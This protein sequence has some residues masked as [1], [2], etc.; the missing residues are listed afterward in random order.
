MPKSVKPWDCKE[1]EALKK[2]E[3]LLRYAGGKRK[4]ADEIMASFPQDFKYYGEP[5]CGALNIFLRY[6]GKTKT[7]NVLNDING[8][9]INFLRCLR[10]HPDELL[11]SIQKSSLGIFARDIGKEAAQQM[12]NPYLTDIQRAAAFFILNKHSFGGTT[13]HFSF[14]AKRSSVKPFNFEA[15]KRIFALCSEALQY[16]VIENL[17]YSKFIKTLD[18]SDSFFYLDPPYYACADVYQDNFKHDDFVALR[19]QLKGI[20]GKFLMSLNGHPEVLELFK[21]FRIWKLEKPHAY[22][23]SATSNKT[24]AHEILICN[25]EKDGK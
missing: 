21:D 11:N 25:Y 8:K 10:E 17:H 5:F 19:D 23:L 3:V 15:C 4:L 9:L 24:P 6:R 16:A 1:P 14:S 2:N 12:N 13:D 20:Q 18:R 22:T 7:N